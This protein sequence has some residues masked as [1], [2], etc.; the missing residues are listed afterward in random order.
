L[1]NLT[2]PAVER[3]RVPHPAGE[4]PDDMRA[5]AG[6]YVLPNRL[7]VIASRAGHPDLVADEPGRWDHVSVSR[8]DRCPTWD[9][10]E[11]VKRLFFKR[12]ETAMQLHV[13][14]TDHVNNHP[15]CLHLWRPLP[16]RVIPR[17]PSIMVGL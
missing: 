9:E 17:P 2:D 10:M 12:D 14:P 5:Y 15:Y 1:I 3:Y 11:Y 8:G 4:L 13:P 6:A 16:P 7:R